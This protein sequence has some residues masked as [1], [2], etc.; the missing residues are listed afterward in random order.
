MG[1]GREVLL[2]LEIGR[3]IPPTLGYSFLSED[4]STDRSPSL[5]GINERILLP[6]GDMITDR[7]LLVDAERDP[8]LAGD[9]DKETF[10]VWR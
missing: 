10:S 5:R 4:V 6:P 9:K 7:S 2:S 3:E 8:S 1:I